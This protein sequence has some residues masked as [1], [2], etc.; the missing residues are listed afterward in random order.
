MVD[1]RWPQHDKFTLKINS[2]PTILDDLLAQIQA[3]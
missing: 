3:G 1:R 2:E